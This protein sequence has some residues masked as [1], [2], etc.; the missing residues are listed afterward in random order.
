MW[1]LVNQLDVAKSH[2]STK[3]DKE[4]ELIHLTTNKVKFRRFIVIIP[5]LDAILTKKCLTKETNP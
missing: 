2:N 3:N 4:I 5:N 1:S